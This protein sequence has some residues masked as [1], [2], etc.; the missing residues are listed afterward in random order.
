MIDY[1]DS[2]IQL[3]DDS[4]YALTPKIIVNTLSID[5][6]YNSFYIEM[7]IIPFCPEQENGVYFLNQ[8]FKSKEKYWVYIDNYFCSN[9]VYNLCVKSMSID[10]QGKDLV[11]SYCVVGL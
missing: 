1:F 5:N 6:K 7:E 9:V 2:E 3:F 11:Y 10:S 4:G 8:V